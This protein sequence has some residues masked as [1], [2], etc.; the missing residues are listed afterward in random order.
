MVD[1][2]N[3]EALN[4]IESVNSVLAEIGCGKSPILVV[5]NK[6]D[7]VRKV[8][9]FE[10]LQTLYPDAVCISAKTGLGL[11]QLSEA[12]LSRYKGAVVLLRVSSSQSDG[13]V[14]SFLRAY[15]KIIEEQYRDGNVL[16]EATLGRNQIPSLKR[17]HPEHVEIVEG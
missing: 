9:D 14:Q 7:I 12:V 17:L 2:S 5:L 3:P 8:S 1:V 15:G 13:R 6:V 4:Q 16:I 10:M 11:E